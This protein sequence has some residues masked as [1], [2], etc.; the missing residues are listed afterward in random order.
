MSV[1]PRCSAKRAGEPARLV[2]VVADAEAQVEAVGLAAQ[3]EE[4]VPDG[5]AVLAARHRHQGP[6]A[7]AAASRTS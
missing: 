4:D 7:R 3:L 6:F 1:C 2:A 5:Q